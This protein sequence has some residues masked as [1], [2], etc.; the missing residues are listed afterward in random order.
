MRRVVGLVRFAARQRGRLPG[1]VNR[2]LDWIRW[3]MP[4]GWANALTG[5]ARIR[6]DWDPPEA[7]IRPPVPDAPVR[8]LIGPAN[9]AGQGF[10]WARALE[11][12]D[13]EVGAVTFS[14][15]REGGFGFPSDYSVSTLVYRRNSRWQRDQFSYLTSG[16]TH[17]IAE[18][19]RPICGWLHGGDPLQE[20]AALAEA[21]VRVALLSHGSDSRLPRRH[22]ERQ[23]WSPFRDSDWADV[24]WLQWQ[25]ERFVGQLRRFP[26][27]VFVSTPDLL[28]DLP[29]ATWCPVVVEPAKWNSDAPVVER[30]RPVVVHAPS[31][32][33]IKGTELVDAAME[34]LAARGLIEYRRIGRVP[35]GEM[36]AVYREAD[37]V[38]DQFR[39]GSYG[40]AACEAMAAGRVVVGNLSDD[41]RTRVRDLTGLAVPVVQATPATLAEVVEALVENRAE[42][43]AAG[44][45]GRAFVESVHSGRRSVAVLG[46]FLH[47]E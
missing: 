41:V 23:E 7:R 44:R 29:F 47:G 30:E 21:G 28:D 15:A 35:F 8:L 31:H 22:A 11:R 26:G 2:A 27:P 33:R 34:P 3:R 25:A 36:P 14:I 42:A 39:L 46:T 5:R 13:P 24:S 38:L 18:V 45:A 1:W 16:F 9:F 37:V 43:V 40:A 17:V 12:D 6:G 10:A 20:A 19:G 4:Q 32:D